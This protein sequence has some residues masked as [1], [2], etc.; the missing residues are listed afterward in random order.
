MTLVERN[1][2]V[3]GGQQHTAGTKFEYLPLDPC[4]LNTE[5]LVWERPRVALGKGPIARAW[6]TATAVDECLLFFGGRGEKKGT[7]KYIF[8]D[9]Q[10]FD[11]AEM[12]WR[13]REATGRLPTPRYWHSAVL[14]ERKLIVWGGH[15]GK[16]S[17]S[18]LHLLDCDA[19]VWS[20]PRPSSPAPPP[21]S[22]HSC[23]AIDGSLV[24]FGGMSCLHDGDGHVSITYSSDVWTLDCLTLEWSRLRQRG[25]APKG[26]AYH[27]APLTPGGQLLVIGGWRGGAVPSDELSALDLTTGVWHP[28]QVPGE[29]PSG[30]YGHTA[31]VV[32]TKVVVF[33]GWDAVNPMNIVHVLD[34]AKL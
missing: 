15:N 22:C 11:L 9:L 14:V 34:T 17:L 16:L 8:N 24:V 18:D 28:V 1:I 4:V 26:V 29:T 5:T 2:I 12:A 6:H 23:C 30:M 13:P 32:G 19:F 10:C 20:Q 27:A 21:L 31:V 25:M 33:G 7:A 3:C